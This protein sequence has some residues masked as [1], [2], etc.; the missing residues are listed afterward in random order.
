MLAAIYGTAV[1]TFFVLVISHFFFHTHADIVYAYQPCEKVGK[2]YVISFRENEFT[3]SALTASRCDVLI[4]K[5]DDKMATIEPAFGE[6]PSHVQYAGFS[7][8]VLKPGQ[9]NTFIL[10]TTGVFDFHDH[11]DDLAEGELT[12]K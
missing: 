3:P 4:F 10:H 1:F 9:E 2:Q 11:L 7:E 12:V 6:H 5:N 8:K